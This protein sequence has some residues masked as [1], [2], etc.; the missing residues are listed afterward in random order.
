MQWSL[1]YTSFESSFN[2]FFKCVGGIAFTD[3]GLA[4]DQHDWGPD[5]VVD[6]WT[7]EMWKNLMDLYPYSKEVN[8][9]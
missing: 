5:A 3:L 1:P 4:D 6:P 7:V 2:F 8:Y 9:I